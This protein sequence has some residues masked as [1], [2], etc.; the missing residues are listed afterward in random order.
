MLGGRHSHVRNLIS[1]GLQE[2]FLKQYF[3]EKQN[4]YL[5]SCRLREVIAMR[6]L[7]VVGEAK[8]SKGLIFRIVPYCILENLLAG[9]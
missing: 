8:K 4:S 7:T 1:G 6:E 9:L 2:M 5:Q 3:T